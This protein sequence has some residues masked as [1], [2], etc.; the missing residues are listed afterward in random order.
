MAQLAFAAAGAALGNAIGGT[1]LG[2]SSASLGWSIGA[3]VGNALFPQDLGVNEGPR[4]SSLKVSS[5]TYGAEINRIYGNVRIP[6]N[7]IWASDIQEHR[8]EEEFGGKGGP[9]GTN[10]TYSYT[11]NFAVALCEG[12]IAGVARIWADTI[13]IYEKEYGSNAFAIYASELSQR[14]ITI[15]TGS[16]TQNPD[17]TIES[18][19][20]TGNVPAF[21]GL[22]YI[23]FSDF[24]LER[25]GNRIPNITVEVVKKRNAQ[26]QL[27]YTDTNLWAGEDVDDFFGNDNGIIKFSDS[28]YNW[29]VL[30]YVNEMKCDMNG[31]VLEKKKASFPNGYDPAIVQQFL[32][33]IIHSDFYYLA[34]TEYIGSVSVVSNGKVITENLQIPFSTLSYFFG[35]KPWVKKGDY[36]YG[37]VT[38]KTQP[39]PYPEYMFRYSLKTGDYIYVQENDSGVGQAVI[40]DDGYV[41]S[42]NSGDVKRYDDDLNLIN[43]FTYPS[44]VT[45]S[46]AIMSA[47]SSNGY[48]LMTYVGAA[49][50]TYFGLFKIPKDD[51]ELTEIQRNVSSGSLKVISV[52]DGIAYYPDPSGSGHVFVSFDGRNIDK[53]TENLSD[54]LS[55]LCKNARLSSSDI[56]VS[57][58]S[59]IVDGYIV[60]QQSVRSSIQTLQQ[61]YHF[62]AVETG[63]KLKFVKRL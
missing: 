25:F 43:T 37:R 19:E 45:S 5:S 39:S 41:Y 30:L 17:P 23:V 14:N 29:P 44:S 48:L 13:L 62:D 56:D 1:V 7:V 32:T 3:L 40:G 12:E 46:N 6:G 52:G 8:Q 57:G 21:R 27:Y 54:V 33:P 31:N 11:A 9:T 10:V 35:V 59:D 61:A 26:S 63:F 22:A 55:S 36:I 58:I 18:F 50:I 16:E 49:S 60:G 24:G 34:P 38:D 20:G 51:G 42:I 2:I 4:L 28:V 47:I 15:Y 53:T